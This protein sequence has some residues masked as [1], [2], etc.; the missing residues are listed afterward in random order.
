M[1]SSAQNETDNIDQSIGELIDAILY[2]ANKKRIVN[3]QEA[4][5]QFIYL[6]Y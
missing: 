1:P 3:K 5:E 2:W 4:I 6:T